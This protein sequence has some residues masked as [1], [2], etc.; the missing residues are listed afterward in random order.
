MTKGKE[1][2]PSAPTVSCF[3]ATV[4]P[5]AS[6]WTVTFS[7]PVAPGR[8]PAAVTLSSRFGLFGPFRSS[9]GGPVAALA[10][11]AGSATAPVAAMVATTA[12]S[13]PPLRVMA[14]AF[15]TIGRLDAFAFTT[16]FR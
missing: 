2:L 7:P 9:V 16:N 14:A 8:F 6:T 1:K 10:E 11:A 5:L 15:C 4:L 13:F 3:F 12:M